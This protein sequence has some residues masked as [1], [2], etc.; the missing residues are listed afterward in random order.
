MGSNF[1]GAKVEMM[2]EAIFAKKALNSS[3]VMAKVCLGCFWD[4]Y[5]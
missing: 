5:I 1:G 3:G 4:F 2:S